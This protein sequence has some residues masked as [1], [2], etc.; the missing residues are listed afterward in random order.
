MDWKNMKILDFESKYHKRLISKMIHV[1]EQKND[2]LNKSTKL[3]NESYF[4]IL[5]RLVKDT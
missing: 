3:L 2:L 5:D 4:N 1:K